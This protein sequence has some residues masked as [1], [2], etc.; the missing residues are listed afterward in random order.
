MRFSK[1]A[2]LI[3]PTGFDTKSS[4][5]DPTLSLSCRRY[6]SRALSDV[7]FGSDICS[8]G[9][10]PPE[11]NGMATHDR[12]ST[13]SGDWVA[14]PPLIHDRVES[15]PE[16]RVLS[17]S[18][19]L[20]DEPL[21]AAQGN[22]TGVDRSGAQTLTP[23]IFGCQSPRESENDGGSGGGGG[24]GGGRDSRGS[25][26]GGGGRDSRGGGGSGGGGIGGGGG[27][28][29][30]GSGGVGGDGIGELGVG[31]LRGAVLRHAARQSIG[32]LD[33]LD[34]PLPPPGSS[35][36]VTERD[37]LGGVVGREGG[38]AAEA[39]A[40]SHMLDIASFM[41]KAPLAGPYT[42]SR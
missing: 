41:H 9:G 39:E 24:G 32:T 16:D 23:S 2:V 17:P 19:P 40:E 22:G 30:M 10:S 35:G 5:I 11:H 34:L 33:T 37:G 26:G 27:R 7:G 6:F 18:P 31:G 36:V 25:G 8:L 20:P 15:M 28:S 4:I 14:S 1:W 13:G 38:G 12:L 21:D 3:G 42:R 29:S